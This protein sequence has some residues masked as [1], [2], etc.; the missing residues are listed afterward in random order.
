VLAVGL[1][2]AC[3]HGSGAPATAAHAAGTAA[4]L[5]P[6]PTP[7][8][9]A[10]GADLLP[11]LTLPCLAGGPDVPLRGLT[12]IPTVINLWA[13]WCGPC[14]EELPAFQ[15]LS[16]TAGGRLRV[17]GVA[18]EDPA[19]RA[20]SFAA[21]ASVHFPSMLDET[22]RLLRDVGRKNMPTTLFVDAQGRVVEVYTG[23]PFTADT[24]TEH[25]RA[26]LGVDAG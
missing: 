9:T 10:S 11:D 26:R 14:R 13:S 18:V 2:A 1:L 21:D 6:C 16:A 15:R 7:A 23:T 8:A 17:L 24:L 3:G 22:G 12:G 25:V 4:R 5:Q 19:G 20:L